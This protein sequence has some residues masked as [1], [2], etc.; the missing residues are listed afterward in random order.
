L[1]QKY[2]DEEF[3]AAWQKAAG[4]PQTVAEILGISIRW[5]YKRR[6]RIE[7][8]LGISL[9]TV[10]RAPGGETRPRTRAYDRQHDFELDTG[11]I[12]IFSDAHWWPDQERTPAHKALIKLIQRLK[13]RAVVANGD[14]FDG[15]RVSRHAPMGWVDAP[16][17]RQELD[18]C[19]DNMLEI[20][21]AAPN[22]CHFQWNVGNHDQRFDRMLATQASEYEG[23]VDRL[24]DRFPEWAFAWSF[25]VNGE[26]MIKHR[27]AGGIHTGYNNTLKSGWTTVTGHT[28]TL[29]VK[30]WADYNGRRWGVQTGTLSDML[31]DQFEYTENN[32]S[33]SGQGFAVITYQAGVLLPPELCE[34]IDGIAYFRGEAV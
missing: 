20:V 2:T 9:S 7:D 18:I 24:S 3:V 30:P 11:S 25:A 6:S 13:P 1:P 27:I 10:P 26:V 8:R 14:V 23:V 33:Y 21:T 19:L 17:V 15:A 5:V 16:T 32:P 29:E 28:H 34:V 12:I 4:S 22:G 31:A